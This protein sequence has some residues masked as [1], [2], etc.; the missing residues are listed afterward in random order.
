MI[1]FRRRDENECLNTGHTRL[2]HIALFDAGLPGAI[3]QSSNMTV[4]ALI[5]PASQLSTVSIDAAKPAARR[6][7][8]ITFSFS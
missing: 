1:I 2:L 4:G 8:D 5:P 6:F 7:A 3:S